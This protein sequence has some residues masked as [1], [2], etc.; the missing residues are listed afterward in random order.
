MYKNL[1]Y[2]YYIL[3]FYKLF[4]FLFTNYRLVLFL[5]FNIFYKLNYLG[6]FVAVFELISG[7]FGDKTFDDPFEVLKIINIYSIYI[8]I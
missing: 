6:L 7:G 2:G 4:L 5:Y 8:N 3:F 1:D